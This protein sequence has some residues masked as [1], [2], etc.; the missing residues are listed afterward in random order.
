MELPNQEFSSGRVRQYRSYLEIIYN[1]MYRSIVLEA[2]PVVRKQL[3]NLLQEIKSTSASGID[4]GL[5][6]KLTFDPQY[7]AIN[8][9]IAAAVIGQVG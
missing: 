7:S 2:D 4:I 9:E 3:I 5:W 1:S 6:M 8:D